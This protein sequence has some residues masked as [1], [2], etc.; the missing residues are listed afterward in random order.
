MNNT[1]F[2]H[3]TILATAFGMLELASH[4][5]TLT[6]WQSGSPDRPATNQVR[7]TV[8]GARSRIDLSPALT[9]LLDGEAGYAYQILHP[10]KAYVRQTLGAFAAASPCADTKGVAAGF[11][12]LPTAV[13]IIRP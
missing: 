8:Q 10:A 12:T 6:V 4:G 5:A 2:L 11:Q 3:T 1:T 7:V 9:Y 13:R